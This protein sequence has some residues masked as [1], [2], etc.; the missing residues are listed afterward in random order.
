MTTIRG[1]ANG[2]PATLDITGDTLTWRAMRVGASRGPDNVATTI[3]DIKDVAWIERRWSSAGLGLGVLSAL[4][5][6][7]EGA[8]VGALGL[9]V[10]AALVA[11]T[12][13]RPTRRLLIAC[14]DRRLALDVEAASAAHARELAARIHQA[15]VGGGGPAS[16]PTL[17]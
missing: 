2:L 3:H 9:V 13:R 15:L 4:W 5:I 17:P 11:R 10:A 14:G 7:S 16:T 8:V 6:A 12:Y 1:H